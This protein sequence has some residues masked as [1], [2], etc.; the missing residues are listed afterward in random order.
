MDETDATPEKETK[1]RRTVER[2]DFSHPTTG[3]RVRVNF[4]DDGSTRVT[5]LDSRA[6]VSH[7]WA[8]VASGSGAGSETVI[9]PVP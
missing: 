3:E 8:T 5:Y 1:G 9:T 7:H 4:L 6:M 2:H